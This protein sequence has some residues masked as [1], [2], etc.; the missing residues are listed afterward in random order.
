MNE[1]SNSEGPETDPGR[2][3]TSVGREIAFTLV[4]QA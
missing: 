3:L 2:N 1:G 4:S